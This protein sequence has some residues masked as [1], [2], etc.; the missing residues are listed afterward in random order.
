MTKEEYD[1]MGEHK[2][3]SLKPGN[4]PYVIIDTNSINASIRYKIYSTNN[5]W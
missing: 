4:D 3:E 1:S 2:V 5:N